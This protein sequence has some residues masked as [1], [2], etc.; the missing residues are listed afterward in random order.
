MVF[1]QHYLHWN[2]ITDNGIWELLNT[3]N[4]II[5]ILLHYLHWNRDTAISGSKPFGPVARLSHFQWGM[6]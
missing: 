2:I 5:E 6:S 4:S 3:I 1:E